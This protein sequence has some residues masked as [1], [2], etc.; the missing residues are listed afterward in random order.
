MNKNIEVKIHYPIPIHKL[1][2]SKKIFSK[3]LLKNTEKYSK[4]IL[5]L[6]INQN[7]KPEQILW[8]CKQINN[9]YEEKNKNILVTGGAGFIGS[10][11]VELLLKK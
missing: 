2:S 11:L 6:P 3:I 8:V 1:R 10:H 5:S 4:E 9:F 7:L